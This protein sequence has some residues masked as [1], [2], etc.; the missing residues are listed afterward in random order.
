M[1]YIPY[2]VTILFTCTKFSNFSQHSNYR[3]DKYYSYV[4]CRDCF[5]YVDRHSFQMRK[6]EKKSLSHITVQ[7]GSS[8]ITVMACSSMI[9][10]YSSTIP[11]P[12]RSYSSYYDDI[13]DIW[14]HTLLS[15][16]GSLFSPSRY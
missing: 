9:I 13:E 6:Y 1:L 11:V 10:Q 8:V 12:Y 2:K 7:M 14:T 16:G 3:Y 4:Y 15:P 5:M